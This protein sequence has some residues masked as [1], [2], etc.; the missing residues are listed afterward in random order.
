[1]LQQEEAYD[2]HSIIEEGEGFD[3]KI[4]KKRGNHSIISDKTLG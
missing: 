1:M 2:D 4:P 3:S